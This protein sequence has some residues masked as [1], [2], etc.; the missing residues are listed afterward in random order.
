MLLIIRGYRQKCSISEGQGGVGGKERGECLLSLH[1]LTGF[2]AVSVCAQER[3][4]IYR[5]LIRQRGINYDS[6]KK[7]TVKRNKKLQSSRSLF[8]Q[9]ESYHHSLETA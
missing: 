6:S 2:Q 4:F 7:G 8:S 3:R 9:S 1:V 5:G